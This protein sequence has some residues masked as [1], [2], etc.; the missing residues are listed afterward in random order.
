[1]KYYDERILNSNNKTKTTWDIVKTVTNDRKNSNKI[2][3]M[4][5][6]NHLNNNPVTIVNAFN[7]Y[8]NS[9]AKTY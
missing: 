4:N 8:F 6:D 3:S 5:I 1:M 7:T 2:V 9:V